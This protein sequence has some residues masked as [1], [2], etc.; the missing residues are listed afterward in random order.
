MVEHWSSDAAFQEDET[1]KSKRLSGG[2]N[3]E[4][5]NKG[6]RGNRQIDREKV[7]QDGAWGKREGQKHQ[8]DVCS[9]SLPANPVLCTGN[10]S[11]Q[12]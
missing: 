12:T 6:G 5:Y 2:R 9:C 10:G 3:M 8:A 4:N 7:R 11:L 1:S